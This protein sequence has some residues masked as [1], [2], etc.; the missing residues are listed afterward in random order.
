VQLFGERRYNRFKHGA[1]VQGADEAA[2]VGRTKLRNR[3]ILQTLCLKKD[4]DFTNS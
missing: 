1:N 4:S 2:H 3:D